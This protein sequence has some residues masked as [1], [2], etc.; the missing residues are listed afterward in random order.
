M[1]GMLTIFI[2]G[3]HKLSDWINV[4]KIIYSLQF[5]LCFTLGKLLRSYVHVS[6]IHVRHGGLQPLRFNIDDCLVKI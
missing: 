4:H 1:L 6:A 3:S 5:I 2:E